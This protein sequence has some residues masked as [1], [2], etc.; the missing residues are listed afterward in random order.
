ME[1]AEKI[2]QY[3]VKK[4]PNIFERRDA[5]SNWCTKCKKFNN[6]ASGVWKLL[7]M[8]SDNQD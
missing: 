1:D 4:Y 5:I 3:F 8:S 2:Y 6:L 7:N